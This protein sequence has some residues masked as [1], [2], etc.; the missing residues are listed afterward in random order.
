MASGDWLIFINSG[1]MLYDSNVLMNVIHFKPEKTVDVLY[2]DIELFFHKRNERR[3]LTYPDVID[4]AFLKRQ[5]ICHQALFFKRHLFLD[6]GEYDCTFR[7]ASDFD[8]ILVFFL[9]G[10]VY[11]HVPV[12]ISV[13]VD[14]GVS[15]INFKKSILERIAILENR[16]KKVGFATYARH[17]IFL[18]LISLKRLLTGSFRK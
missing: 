6:Y 17:Y 7:I 16:L 4:I 3:I 9:A 15:T 8:R 5:T 11:H 12:V 10:A 14:D 18:V 2:G 13:F 1:D